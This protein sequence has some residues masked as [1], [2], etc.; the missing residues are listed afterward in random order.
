MSCQELSC[1]GISDG[2]DVDGS[3]L[4]QNIQ[5]TF[6]DLSHAVQAVPEFVVQFRFFSFHCL[7]ISR[8]VSNP[9]IKHDVIHI[10]EVVTLWCY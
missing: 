10:E 5:L 4:V 2:V 8:C 6:Q 3:N 7:W 1:L 9:N